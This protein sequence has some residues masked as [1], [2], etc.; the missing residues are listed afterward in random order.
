MRAEGDYG[1]NPGDIDASS[2]W[3]GTVDFL[4]IAHKVSDH[5]H[6]DNGNYSGAWQI[7]HDPIKTR[8]I[9]SAFPH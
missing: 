7:I 9:A 8:L 3:W 4:T 6:D 5:R 1:P 2:N